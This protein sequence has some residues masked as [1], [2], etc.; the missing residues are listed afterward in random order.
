MKEMI[1]H[2][3]YLWD[4]VADCALENAAMLVEGGKVKRL[5]PAE[6]LRA[7]A[8]EAQVL[9]SDSWLV[10][11]AF[12]DA[13]DHG[14]G[15]TPSSMRVPDQALEIWL[16]DL[17]KLAPIPHQT[18]CWFDGVR[19]AASGV[20]T[21]LHS[22]NPNDFFQMKDELTAA[23]HGY[24]AAGVRSILCPLFI[25]QNKRIYY[26]RDDFI[27][28]L[29]E[30][31]RT[32]FAAGI[33]DRL[34]SLEDYFAL[35]EE[36][37]QALREEIDA[38]WVEVQLHPNGG[39]W[40]SDEALLAMK[41]YALSHGMHIHLHLLETQY[42]AEYALRTWGKSFIRHYRDIGF[43]GPWVSFAHAVWLSGE[44]LQ[45]IKESGAVLVNN[46]SSNLRL[47]S[48]AFRLKRAQ[49]L[50]LTVGIGMDGCTLDDDQDYLREMRVAWLNN[51]CTG[52]DARIDPRFVLKMATSKG[53]RVA[54]RPLS[55][56]VLAPGHNADFVCISLERLY[57]PY[58]EPDSDPLEMTVQR[59]TRACVDCTWVN[60]VQTY[61]TEEKWRLREA[62]AARTI[63]E[64]LLDL[65][66]RD[67]GRRDNARLLGYVRDFYAREG[68]RGFDWEGRR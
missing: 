18:A 52:V 58:S 51:G 21:V 60:G 45:L 2:P 3:R 68:F 50:D 9:H 42:Q 29:P 43:L 66:A 54:A 25:D 44:D 8:P 32:S 64:T 40:C 7:L 34:M 27:A 20:G 12:V 61:G 26:N 4:G 49:E 67:D 59:G 28:G 15:V 14:R 46:A 23:A 36:T 5:G 6:E 53:A 31:L 17:N 48:G 47:R 65:R 1:I 57:Y 16:Q 62:E 41:E 19:M 13:H 30:P 33:H 37:C 38:G 39:Q 63:R 24:M 55:E 10:L 56:G 35:I 11:P 22:H